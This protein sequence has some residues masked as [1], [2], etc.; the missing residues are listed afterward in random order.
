MHYLLL[1]IF[2]LLLSC[3][4]EVNYRIDLDLNGEWQF[5]KIGDK[6]WT[7]ANVP[8]VVQLD[9]LNAGLIENPFYGKN[10][11]K[12]DW[13]GNENWEYKR[14]FTVDN[15]ILNQ[16]IVDLVFEGLDTYAEIKINGKNILEA[17]NMF[18]SW[19]INCKQELK[20]GKNTISVLFKS[21]IKKK[22]QEY[23]RLGYKL[24]AGNDAGKIKISPFVRK[25]PY[26][27]GWDWGPRIVTM[28]IWRPV[29][30]E[31]YS[32]AKIKD[33]YFEQKSVETDWANVSCE[34]ELDVVTK[35]EFQLTV[36]D[37][38]Q[39][40]SQKMIKPQKGLHKYTLDFAIKNPQLWWTNGLGK[41]HLYNWN[42]E[43][44]YKNKILS[45][46]NHKIGLRKIELIQETDSIGTNYYFKLNGV[47]VFMKGANYIPQDN[48]L[49]RVTPNHYKELITNAADANMNMLRVWGGGI[50]E[51]DIFYNL[52]DELGILVWQDFMFACSMYPGDKD[53]LSS[54]QK[55]I[56]QNVKRLR[57]HPCIALWCGNNEIQIAWQYWGWQ[58]KFGYSKKD[59]SKISR[60]YNK[61]FKNLI[62]SELKKLKTH[63]DYVHTSPLSNWGRKEN[64]N[65][66]SMHYWGVWHGNEPFENYKTNIGRFMSEYGFQSFP[67]M[68]SIKLFADSSQWFLNSE[69]MAHHQKSY[70]GNG[71]IKKHME[72]YFPTPNTFEEFVYLSQLTQT[73]GIET[74]INSHRKTRRCM[75]T[76][77]WQMND[78]WPGPSWSGIDYY[79]RWKA[80]HYRVKHLYEDISIIIDQGQE[81]NLEII[82]SSDKLTTTYGNLKLELISF[83]GDKIWE[84][85][86]PITI[87]KN[88]SQLVFK[89]NFAKVLKAQKTN[90]LFLKVTAELKDKN[91]QKLYYFKRPKDL[92]LRQAQ[93][94]KTIRKIPSGYQLDLFSST[95]VKNLFIQIDKKEG[96]CS[97]NYFD[98]L[99]KEK[100]VINIKT[101]ENLNTTDINFL[102]INNLLN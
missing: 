66:H 55:E 2:I 53:F 90:N 48:L 14:S 71:M 96:N 80:L 72:E 20:L 24:P 69:V 8:G 60:N 25:A 100:K 44:K 95:L 86:T 22:E 63:R 46:E 101:S 18:C 43:L 84:M 26:H 91:Y 74:A 49:P 82:I 28:G 3:K 9:M 75:G 76:L 88:S 31:S 98:L 39:I 68:K 67:E 16:D 78:C 12:I 29:R 17:N 6:Q 64:F 45:S 19:R 15:S 10:E 37:N 41:P 61:I 34:I 30:L 51:N 99:P 83:N 77:Y 73:L 56:N 11:Y 35:G 58:E 92:N 59:S 70:I 7:K 52:C 79:G 38:D 36:K 27:F 85:K 62:P 65:H 50:Y 102:S 93:I 4:S 94:Q 40:L 97:E 54:V 87:N 33:I 57:N 81:N 5:Q 42:I 23:N 21:P 1:L 89:K 32:L 13:I 47:P